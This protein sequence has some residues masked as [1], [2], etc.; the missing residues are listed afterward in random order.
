VQIVDLSPKF[1]VVVVRDLTGLRRFS[2]RRRLPARLR[3]H[4]RQA[5]GPRVLW[6]TNPSLPTLAH[7]AEWS[8]T[9]YDRSDLWT[10]RRETSLPVWKRPRAGLESRLLVRAESA[11]VM[12]ATRI[13]AVSPQI[14]SDLRAR[15]GR[16]V[17]EIVENGV[18][19][20]R[21]SSVRAAPS[22]PPI[23]LYAG[24]LKPTI[25]FGLLRRVVREIPEAELVLAGPISGASQR[26]VADLLGEPNVRHVGVLEAGD[27]DTLM[28]RATVGLLPYRDCEWI[29]ASSPLKLFEYL[30]AGLP[31]VAS[32]I[33][34]GSNRHDG[35]DGYVSVGGPDAFVEECRR[36]IGAGKDP[37]GQ[38]AR[39]AY[40]SR[41][42]WTAKL[43]TIA[44]LAMRD[45]VG[46]GSPTRQRF[47][48]RCG[49]SEQVVAK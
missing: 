49:S 17:D 7:A 25:D 48:S 43:T 38:Q 36:L 4:L 16:S 31:A 23:L 33:A 14:G 41:H 6:Y 32:G 34:S 19:F 40:A 30:A 45:P 21:F 24:A 20:K 35:G 2:L 1:S 42:D 39:R 8:A 37:E 26:D 11:I 28:A 13:V 46:S 9:V 18:D 12:S 3:A 10:A 29:A 22:S 15:Y 5:A 47:E 44:G 27:L